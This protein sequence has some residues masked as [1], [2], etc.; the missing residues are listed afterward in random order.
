MANDFSGDANCVAL[1]RFESGA[2]TTDSKGT[3]TL[4]NNN[5]VAENAV[6]YKEGAGSADFEASSTQ[7]F[8][9][10]DANLDAGFPL[11]NG[12]A[13]KKISI[14]GWFQIE[15]LRPDNIGLYSKWNSGS[16]KASLRIFVSSIGI[17]TVHIGYNGGAS[18][19][20]LYSGVTVVTGRFYHY[21]FTFQDSDKTWQLVV[22]DDTGLTK[23]IDTSGIA[24]NNINVEDAAVAIGVGYINVAPPRMPFDGEI[25]EKPVFKDIFV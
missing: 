7:Y 21:G 18:S 1:W 3:N 25:D 17:F 15:T 16:N 6:D 24:T 23:I 22:W 4:T 9:I 13:N 11:K 5:A 10:T 20:T 12:D 14:C 2:L 19:E 8:S